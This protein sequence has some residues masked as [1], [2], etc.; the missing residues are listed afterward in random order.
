MIKRFF[1]VV[2]FIL[3]LIFGTKYVLLARGLP[4]TFDNIGSNGIMVFMIE[5]LVI[6]LSIVAYYFIKNGS[7]TFFRDNIKYKE[8][9]ES[10]K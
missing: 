9:R 6:I 5:M 3:V 8:K 2:V 1:F 7:I 4:N 10:E